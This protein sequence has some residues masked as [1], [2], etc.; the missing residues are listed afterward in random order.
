MSYLFC[1][2]SWGDNTA[3]ASFNENI[4]AWDTSGVIYMQSLFYQ[5]Y[6]F[7]Q[8][9]SDWAVHSVTRMDQMFYRASAF[10]QDLGWCPQDGVDLNNAFESTQC[11]STSCGVRS[12]C[13]TLAPTPRP[14]HPQPTSQLITGY[15]MTDSNIKTAVAA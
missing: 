2:A 6:A 13:W 14:T 3:A 8:D 12:D 7:N 15:V 5:A 11:E 1:G 9:I 4:G 10:N